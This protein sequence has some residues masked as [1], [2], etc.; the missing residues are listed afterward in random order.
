MSVENIKE[1]YNNQIRF[2][3]QVIKRIGYNNFKEYRQGSEVKLPVDDT[4]LSSYHIQGLMSEVGE[5]LKAD[6]RWKNYRI[7]NIDMENKLEEIADCFIFIMNIA[8]FSGFSAEEFSAM[9]FRKM[10]ENFVR[11]A[12]RNTTDEQ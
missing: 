3:E 2:Q 5:I 9:I 1:I 12:E 4:N 11:I 10:Q 8:I 6:K 7:D